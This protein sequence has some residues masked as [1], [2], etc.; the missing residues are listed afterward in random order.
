[1]EAQT[2][3]VEHCAQFG[4]DSKEP[5]EAFQVAELYSQAA[6]PAGSNWS[7]CASRCV[8]A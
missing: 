2:F 6:R 5:S 7:I 4:V 1:M 3:H 8:V